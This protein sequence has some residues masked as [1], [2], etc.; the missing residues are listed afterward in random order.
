MMR[1][2]FVLGHASL[3]GGVRVIAIHADGLRRLGHE[4]QVISTP[5]SPITRPQRILNR[6]RRVGWPGAKPDPSHFDTLQVPHK[7]IECWRPIEDGDVPDADMV[8]ATFWRTAHWVSDLSPSKGKKAVFFQGF[9]AMDGA[10]PTGLIDA[11][12]LPLYKITISQWLVE[13]A[14]E[15]FGDD[16]VAHVPNSVDREQF[17][18]PKRGRQD[19][20]TVGVL[21][22]PAYVKGF[23]VVRQVLV[24]LQE[25]IPNLRIIAFGA[26]E[27]SNELQMP[28][29]AEFQLQP[30]Q[31]QIR[32]IYGSCD[33]WLCGSRREGFH[34]VPL[35]AM[36]CRCPVVSTAVGG[37]LDT[38]QN[39]VNGYIVPIEDVDALTEKAALVLEASSEHWQAMSDAAFMTGQDYTWQQATQRFEAALEQARLRDHAQ[40]VS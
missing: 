23:D 33:L 1:I 11:W 39:G 28:D 19:R 22:H 26:H 2:T 31:Q 32:E 25:R 13:L 37:P 9:E 21:Y 36:A 20:P 27:P 14:R 12:K 35:E 17:H 5:S 4:V 8:V 29:G 3:S 7:M 18:A 15:R 24:R 38:L 6:L 40:A 34:L 16:D 10:E 30:P